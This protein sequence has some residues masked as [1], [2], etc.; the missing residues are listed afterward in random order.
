MKAD[1]K[2]VHKVTRGNVVV[3]IREYEKAGRLNFIVDYRADGLRRLVWRSTITDAKIAAN[4]AIDR[5]L[6]G[7]AEI[8]QLRASDA[9]T[10]RRAV[11]NLDGLDIALDEVARQRGTETG[12]DTRYDGHPSIRI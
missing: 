9:Q 1:E 2:V 4:E 8:L 7:N 5:I 12:S 10:Y 6:D 3:R 11:R